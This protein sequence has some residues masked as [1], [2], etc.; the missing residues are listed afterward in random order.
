[1]VFPSVKPR[2]RLKSMAGG[3]TKSRRIDIHHHLVPPAYVAATR[4]LGMR[5]Y[6]PDWS[7]ELSLAD[8]DANGIATAVM[9]L[10]Q[11]QVWFGDVALARRLAR[12]S[13]EYGA[14]LAQNHPGR[15]G[16]F[17][18]LPLPDADGSLH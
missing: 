1:M 9:S 16:L 15:F 10:I 17:G 11:P 5:D 4:E 7:P 3:E 6:M 2:A 12:E 14:R 13:N 8:M 18:V